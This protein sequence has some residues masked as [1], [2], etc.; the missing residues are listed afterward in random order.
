MKRRSFL[1]LFVAVAVGYSLLL[2]LAI[3]CKILGGPTTHGMYCK[4]AKI[5]M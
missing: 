1:V 5:Y 2:V 4:P 3:L